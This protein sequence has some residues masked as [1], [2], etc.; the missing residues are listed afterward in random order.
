M[1]AQTQKAREAAQKQ[2]N[3]DKAEADAA[4]EKRIAAA[5]A[6][7]EADEKEHQAAMKARRDLDAKQAEQHKMEMLERKKEFEATFKHL[8]GASTFGKSVVYATCDNAEE[9]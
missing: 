6:P 2:I 5:K 1:Q 9:A 3:K 7:R 4:R 8:W